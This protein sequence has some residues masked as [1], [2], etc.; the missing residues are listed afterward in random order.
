M[1]CSGRCCSHTMTPNENTS[2]FAC[3]FL[4]RT[5]SGLTQCGVPAT[6]LSVL[7][8]SWAKVLS[9]K[10]DLSTQRVVQQHVGALEVAVHDVVCVQVRHPGCHLCHNPQRRHQVQRVVVHVQV[11]VKRPVVCPAQH[12]RQRFFRRVMHNA[13]EVHNAWVPQAH[14]HKRLAVQAKRIAGNGTGHPRGG[15]RGGRSGRGGGGG[16]WC[17]LLC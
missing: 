11:V 16:C 3:S 6:L 10:I 13:V 14:E 7:R 4:V 2:V 5:C 1:A 17:F 9:P 12:K 15:G 8:W